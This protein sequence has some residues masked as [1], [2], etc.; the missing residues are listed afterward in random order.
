ML[1]DSV[2]AA[3]RAEME[4]LVVERRGIDERIAAI[5][6]VLQDKTSPFLQGAPHPDL[7]DSQS[8]LEPR[9]AG[10]ATV[11]DVVKAV[12]RERPGAKAGTVTKVLRN[13]GY[14]PGG[15]TRLSHR[16]Y[17]EMWRM[18][19]TGEAV[20]TEDGGFKLRD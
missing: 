16:V 4:T 6:M 10:T 7:H 8:L 18:V 19:Q 15:E 17:N 2:K 3:L 5:R 12:M 1:S 14:K 9:T 13:R 20:R 11:K